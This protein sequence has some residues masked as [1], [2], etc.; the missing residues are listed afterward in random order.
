MEKEKMKTYLRDMKNTRVQ[1]TGRVPLTLVVNGCGDLQQFQEQ[2]FAQQLDML[3]YCARL[4]AAREA[5]EGEIR[6]LQAA[7]RGMLGSFLP[8]KN[9][10]LRRPLLHVE[11]GGGKNHCA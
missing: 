5:H 10:R 11:E 4:I 3:D 8:G 9:G 6:I 1:V 2:L 7:L